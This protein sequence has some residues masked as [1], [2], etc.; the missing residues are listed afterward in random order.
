MFKKDRCSKPRLKRQQGAA[1]AV[2]QKPRAVSAP[3]CDTMYPAGFGVKR[4]GSAPKGKGIAAACAVEKE[5]ERKRLR[6]KRVQRKKTGRVTGQYLDGTL[7]RQ[8]PPS[9]GAKF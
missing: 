5:R 2:A 3:N 9:H 8:V 4:R 7:E 6:P 1:A